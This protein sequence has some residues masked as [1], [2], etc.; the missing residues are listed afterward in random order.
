MKGYEAIS[1][2]LEREGVDTIYTLMSDGI[3]GLISHVEE[4]YADEI[5]IVETRHEQGAMG[6]ADGQ[7]R[8]TDDVAL[9]AVGRGP[10]I[11][12]AGATLVTARKRGS[13]VLVLVAEPARD[14]VYHSKHFQQTAYLETLVE[15]VV[16]IRSPNTLVS[17]FKAALRQVTVG[18]GPLVVQIPMDVIDGDVETASIDQP[19]VADESSPDKA[20]LQPDPDALTRA[21]QMLSNA[22]QPIVLAGQGAVRANAREPIIDLAERLQ[23][24][25]VTTLQGKDFFANHHLEVGIAGGLGSELANE[26]V[27]QSD[28]VLAVGCS[29]NPFTTHDGT[30]LGDEATVIHVDVDRTTLGRH[31]PVDLGIIGDARLT[32]KQIA[33]D[34]KA[35]GSEC[36]DHG[37]SQADLERIENADPVTETTT[38]EEEVGIDPRA[39]VQTLEG[40]L[41][42][43]RIVVTDVG[44]FVSWVL[45]GIT[46][47]DP[48]NFLWTADFS[49][50]G[51]GIPIGVGAA[52]AADDRTCYTFVGD[53]GFMMALP[54]IE[55]AVRNGVPITVVVI[56]DGVL[57]A[58][59]HEL[60]KDGHYAES[61]VVETP[62]LATIAGSLGAESYTA[63]SLGEIES[64]TDVL[65]E[66]PDSPVV[67]DCRVSRLPHRHKL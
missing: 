17:E 11:A 24:P 63:E 38:A 66:K 36:A 3:M 60:V 10:A 9:C 18:D 30:V 6:M 55:T 20:R 1:H 50:L 13:K 44:H 43:N 22:S 56:N 67:V 5:D 64:L 65:G 25:L 48:R 61:A 33:D 29:L 39:L 8:I 19:I 47:E 4:E 59:Y 51:K 37:L 15:D 34:I 2:V 57:G 28:C 41:A 53:A 45:D 26:L 58:E 52:R 62:D 23:A 46:V 14:A 7:A 31:T 42:E 21:A 35:V 40:I 12:Q 16:S 49:A 32:V 54:E 27:N